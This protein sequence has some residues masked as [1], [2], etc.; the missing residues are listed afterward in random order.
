MQRTKI[1]VIL[2]DHDQYV[3]TDGVAVMRA[4]RAIIRHRN[5]DMNSFNHDIALLR[6]R[7]PVSFSKSIKPVCLPDAGNCF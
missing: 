2:G 1:R 5:F 7:K 4:V 3:N 6:L